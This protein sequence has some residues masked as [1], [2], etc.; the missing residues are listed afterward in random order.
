MKLEYHDASIRMAKIKE[1]D[2]T[3]ADENAQKMEHSYIAGRNKNDKHILKNRLVES[4][5]IK[6]AKT[7]LGMEE[8]ICK[9]R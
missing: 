2:T 6:H 5:K 1:N 3:N 8:N 9:I 7:T 4:Y